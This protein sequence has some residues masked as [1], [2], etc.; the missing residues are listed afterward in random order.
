[1][2]FLEDGVCGD[3]TGECEKTLP[4]GEC[5]RRIP[6]YHTRMAGHRWAR[7]DEVWVRPRDLEVV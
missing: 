2:V 3:V 4:N 6:V 5:L 7:A 1:M